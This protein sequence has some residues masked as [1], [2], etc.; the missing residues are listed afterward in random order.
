MSSYNAPGVFIQ[1]ISSGAQ[2][3]EQAS[4]SVG[5][6][7]GVT[8][9]GLANVAQKISSWTEY[10]LKYANGLDTPFLTNDY[11]SYAVHGFFTNGGKELY[12][13]SVKKNDAVKAKIEKST[14]NSITAV[15]STEGIWGND[16]KIKITKNADYDKDTYPAFDI[17]ISVGS[18]DSVTIMDVFSDEM[19]VESSV[20]DG[21][22]V[23]I[24]KKIDKVED[25]L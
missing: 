24:I 23:K 3:I 13:G 14:I 7:I 22:S 21:C 12:I 1:D 2:S 10:I 15:A 8:K 4:S 6:L 20:G 25:I 11:L 19:T 17:T 16:I 18:S 9:S 5:I